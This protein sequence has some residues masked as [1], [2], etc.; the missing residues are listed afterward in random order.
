VQARAHWRAVLRRLDSPGQSSVATVV[1][2][3]EKRAET[4]GVAGTAT[5]ILHVLRQAVR[6]GETFYTG[7]CALLLLPPPPLPALLLLLNHTQ[8]RCLVRFA[9]VTVP[10][11]W[12]RAPS[13]ASPQPPWFIRVFVRSFVRSFVRLFTSFV[14]SLTRSFFHFPIWSLPRRSFLDG[15]IQYSFTA[16]RVPAV[17]LTRLD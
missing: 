17:A 3:S 8:M 6:F 2:S 13:L 14:H 5:C 16:F 11:R 1:S 7:A 15:F 10:R 12:H 4:T 9:R